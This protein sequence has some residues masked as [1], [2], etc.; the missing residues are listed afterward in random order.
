MERRGKGAHGGGTS[1]VKVWPGVKISHLCEPQPRPDPSLIP[2][3]F[4]SFPTAHTS[5]VTALGSFLRPPAPK[6]KRARSPWSWQ[7][8]PSFLSLTHCVIS[9]GSRDV[10]EPQMSPL[11]TLGVYCSGMVLNTDAVSDFVPKEGC[12]TAVGGDGDSGGKLKEGQGA[13]TIHNLPIVSPF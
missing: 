4:P 9:G 6:Q 11:S 5:V 7:N 13:T 8:H 1:Q 12:L 10:P 2:T 3:R